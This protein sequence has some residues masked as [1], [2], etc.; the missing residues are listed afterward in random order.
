MVLVEYLTG[1]PPAAKHHFGSGSEDFIWYRPELGSIK[2]CVPGQRS[3]DAEFFS[4]LCPTVC[5]N[6]ANLSEPFAT[7][8]KQV[9]SLRRPATHPL[10]FSKTDY[11]QPEEKTLSTFQLF[12]SLPGET[13]LFPMMRS[14]VDASAARFRSSFN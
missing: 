9:L 14:F 1:N 4:V 12:L 13:E 7:H 8:L 10:E 2:F 6:S 5:K 11:V 3:D